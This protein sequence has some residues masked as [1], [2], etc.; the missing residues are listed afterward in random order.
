MK[1]SGIKTI[2]TS[3]FEIDYFSFGSGDRSFIIIPGVGMNSI[4]LSADAIANGFEIFAQRYTVYVFDQEKNLDI[5]YTVPRAADHIAAAMKEIGITQADIFG[6]SQGGMISLSLA[7]HHPELVHA[8]Y[9]GGTL[10]R[11]N[12]RSLN[13]LGSWMELAK[14]DDVEAL[15][16]SIYSNLYSVDFYRN[17]ITVFPGAEKA[18]TPEQMKRFYYMVKS[19]RD[20]DCYDDLDKIKC[21]VFALGSKVDRIL[22]G[23]AT[24]EIADKLGCCCYM[25]PGYG[26][27]FYDEDPD[28]RSKM[29]AQLSALED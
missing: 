25:Y 17:L 19:A 27:A 29:L 13:M 2:K 10:S 21:P 24:L 8:L 15:N 28:F 14:G 9:L 6:A 22:G 16:H 3:T 4:M 11:Q 1:H 7:I 5:N 23:D 12:E 26:H 18:G 20:F